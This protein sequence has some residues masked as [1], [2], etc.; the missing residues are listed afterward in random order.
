MA[1]DANPQAWF[2]SDR[3]GNGAVVAHDLA[4][5]RIFSRGLSDS[6]VYQNYIATVPGNIVLKSF[7]IG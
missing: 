2:G 7:K 1:R 5:T 6:E 4:M 3:A